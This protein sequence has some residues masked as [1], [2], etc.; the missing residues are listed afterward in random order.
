VA[1]R[2]KSAARA[3]AVEPT[4][5]LDRSLWFHHRGCTG[6]HYLLGN[7]HTVPGRM[8]AWCPKEGRSLFVDRADMGSMSA[9]ARCWVAGFL[10]GATP[11]P[12][13]GADGPPDFGSPD[14]RAWERKAQSFH[15][16]GAWTGPRRR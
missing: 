9:H 12:P 1:I 14:Y 6:R 7:A 16:S 11:A 4:G 3:R 2:R 8:L 10:H 5:G 13:A 15:A